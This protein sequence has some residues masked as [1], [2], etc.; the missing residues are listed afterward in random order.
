MA[1]AT[2]V[3]IIE[4]SM[5]LPSPAQAVACTSTAARQGHM[6]RTGM[7]V[8]YCATLIDVNCSVGHEL[9]GPVLKALYYAR[10]HSFV[11]TQVTRALAS[12][13]GAATLRKHQS[14]LH[15]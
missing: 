13:R 7:H 12:F 10:T 2:S 9:T 4:S 15:A 11:T 6:Y 8:M 1:V 5:K 14:I 3:T